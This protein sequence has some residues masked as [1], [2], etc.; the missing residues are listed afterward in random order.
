MIGKALVA[1][2]IDD[3]DRD[4]CD[5]LGSGAGSSKCMAEIGIHLARLSRKITRANEIA[6]D[7]FGLLA[8]DEYQLAPRR[9][10]DLRVRFLRR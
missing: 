10:D 1:F 7:V 9:N 5:L 4:P 2:V 8:R 3:V 6:V